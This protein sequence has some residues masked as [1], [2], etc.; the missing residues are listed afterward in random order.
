MQHGADEHVGLDV[1]L[2]GGLEVA[3]VGFV[4]GGGDE[5]DLEPAVLGGD[6]GDREADA[7]DGDGA[8]R[9]DEGHERRRGGES[10]APFALGLDGGD[11]GE[12]V[13]V[14]LNE[15]ASHGGGRGKGGFEVDAVAGGEAADGGHAEGFGDGVE[16]EVVVSGDVGDGEAAAVDG[17][18]VALGEGARKVRGVDGEAA[19]VV[20][21]F[22]MEDGADG[23]DESGEHDPTLAGG[24]VLDVGA[25]AASG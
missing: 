11:I 1:D 19:P 6:G 14:A 4:E 2:V 20:G 13:D 5:G 18:G 15:V 8:F 9:D 16:G 22:G 23:L 7:G 10:D 24:G 21:G 12:A 17:D 3:E 25:G